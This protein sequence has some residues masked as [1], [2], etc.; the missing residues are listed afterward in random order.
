MQTTERVS[1][2]ASLCALNVVVAVTVSCAHVPDALPAAL[3]GVAPA[4]AG[5]GRRAIA[6]FE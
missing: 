6:S 3:I 4:I 5:R 2:H 1:Q